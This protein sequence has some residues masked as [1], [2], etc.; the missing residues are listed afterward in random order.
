MAV[1]GPDDNNQM[2]ATWVFTYDGQGTYNQ[3]GEK[4]VGTGY[5]GFNNPG[6]G[7][8]RERPVGCWQ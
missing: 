4:L 6:Q 3:V 5:E 7:K 1:G 8:R 2:G